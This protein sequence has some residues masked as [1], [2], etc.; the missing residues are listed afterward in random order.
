MQAATAE[1]ADEVAPQLRRCFTHEVTI[2]APD[3]PQRRALL[4]ALLGAAGRALPPDA[5]ED[6]AAQSAGG[7]PSF[8]TAGAASAVCGCCS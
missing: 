3:R 8:P 6:A 4:A 5:F 2:A 7:L 1:T